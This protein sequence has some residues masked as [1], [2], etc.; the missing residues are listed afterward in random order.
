MDIRHT[1]KA[2]RGFILFLFSFALLRTAV[3]DWNPIPS[4]SMRPT[5]LEGDVV[6]VNRLAYDLKQPLTD[7]V[8]LPLGEPQ[9][10]DV[11]TLNS[12]TDGTRL[13]KRVLGLPGDRIAMRDDVLIL[14]GRPLAYRDAR[15]RGETLAPGWV[16]DA[17]RATEE[18]DGRPHAVQFLPATPAR[19][20]M[21]EITVP[22]GRYFLLGDNRDNSADSRFIG[23]VPREK[24]IGRA[25]HVLVSA[26]W[27]GEDGWRLAPRFSRWVST[28]L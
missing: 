16:V 24:L 6:L 2:N 7:I 8:L 5:L 9:R 3:A 4:A 20:D 28:I 17:V 18:L 23:T 11:V 22:P 10:G 13:I 19:R 14:N 25:H 27:L 12:P 15:R 26:D 1:L 21:T